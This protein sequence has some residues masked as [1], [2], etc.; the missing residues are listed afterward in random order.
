MAT[1]PPAA[2][3]TV[4]GS[5]DSFFRSGSP[6]DWPN[7]RYVR[8][9]TR[10]SVTW[11][12][13]PW[14]SRALFCLLLRKVDRAGVLE[15]GKHELKN[16]IAAL[17]GMPPSVVETAIIPIIDSGA[18]EVRGEFVILPNFIVAQ[19][20]RS[21][22]K[23]RQRD[24]REKRRVKAMGMETE[25]TAD[26]NETPDGAPD[27]VD[28]PETDGDGDD[29]TIDEPVTDCDEMSPAVTPSH[30]ESPIVTLSLAEPSL[31]KLTPPTPQRG[32]APKRKRSPR[33]AEHP[34]VDAALE[35]LDEGRAKVLANPKPS[36]DVKARVLITKVLAVYTL[37]DVRHVV[38]CWLDDCAKAGEGWEP[39]KYF[40]AKTVFGM[41]GFGARVDRPDPDEKPKTQTPA[42]MPKW[43]EEETA[44]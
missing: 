25:S 35:I 27:Q 22:D 11:S 14:E 33:T 30:P 43:A 37:E 20:A 17:V 21:S 29:L 13:W 31:A 32:N 6:V 18:I 9:Y 1:T 4:R 41:T 7:E 16:A 15:T 26:H 10:D 2:G 3:V 42:N 39:H 5:G 40:V 23:Q 12:L 34:D 28:T 19:E 8:L 38:R 44:P 24:S 36:R